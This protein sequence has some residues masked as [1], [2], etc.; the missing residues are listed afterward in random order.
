[1]FLFVSFFLF[2][3]E[4]RPRGKTEIFVVIF[5][6]ALLSIVQVSSGHWS[7]YVTEQQ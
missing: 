1:M 7:V 6:E 3:I 5:V 4:K 2:L